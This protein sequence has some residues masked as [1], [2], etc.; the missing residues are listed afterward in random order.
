MF[1]FVRPGG[2]I[3]Q[4]VTSKQGVVG[5]EHS[6]TIV[7][8]MSPGLELLML[9]ASVVF[10]KCVS[11]FFFYERY[12]LSICYGGVVYKKLCVIVDM[13]E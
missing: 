1:F 9:R 12:G 3:S 10:D 2:L 11:M 8:I 6:T 13:L 4:P 5:S 7:R